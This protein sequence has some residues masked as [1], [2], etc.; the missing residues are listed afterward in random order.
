MVSKTLE[1]TIAMMPETYD[2]LEE[3]KPDDLDMGT[4][5]RDVLRSEAQKA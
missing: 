5:I 3:S 2:R 1:V 4:Y